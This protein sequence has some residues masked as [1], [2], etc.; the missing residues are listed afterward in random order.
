MAGPNLADT[1]RPEPFPGRVPN[2]YRVSPPWVAPQSLH[3]PWVTA[4][5]CV[6]RKV[7]GQRLVPVVLCKQ[8]VGGSSPLVS[9]LIG[10]SDLGAGVEGRPG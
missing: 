2:V 3:L 10:V 8:G 7:A 5:T 4:S 6:N 1:S 9:P